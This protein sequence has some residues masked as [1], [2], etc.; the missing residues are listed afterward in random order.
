MFDMGIFRSQFRVNIETFTNDA[1][2][3]TL[4]KELIYG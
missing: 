4:A 2:A 3:N 1:I